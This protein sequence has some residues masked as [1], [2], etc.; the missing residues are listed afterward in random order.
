M[1]HLR[2]KSTVTE[3]QAQQNFDMKDDNFFLHFTTF[4]ILIPVL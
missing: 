1:I 3:E 4:P 2:W